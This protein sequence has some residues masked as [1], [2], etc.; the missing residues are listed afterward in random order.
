MATGFVT[1]DGLKTKRP[2]AVTSNAEPKTVGR[3]HKLPSD[4][5]ITAS[6][7]NSAEF[8]R[9][10]GQKSSAHSSDQTTPP[11]PGDEKI[12][13]PFISALRDAGYTGTD[14]IRD[15]AANAASAEQIF[16]FFLDQTPQKPWQM[17]DKVMRDNIQL[18]REL[19]SERLFCRLF[20]NIYEVHVCQWF[21]L[22]EWLDKQ[23]LTLP[24]EIQNIGK[25][26]RQDL[27]RAEGLFP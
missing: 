1:V 4:E 22:E 11:K 14:Y 16:R 21:K 23:G 27:L 9:A 15:F 25:K 26:Q 10:S 24:E 8:Q 18:K 6:L 12:P 20:A 7:T 19:A 2:G 5:M 3:S 17:V 13:E